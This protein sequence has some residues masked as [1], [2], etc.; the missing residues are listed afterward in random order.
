MRMKR[1]INYLAAATIFLGIALFVQQA[2]AN[3]TADPGAT[4]GKMFTYAVVGVVICI[5]AAL[6]VYGLY[7]IRRK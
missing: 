3:P 6:S 1:R 2:Y 5:L 7:R 4:A